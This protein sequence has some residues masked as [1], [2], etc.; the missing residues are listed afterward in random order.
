MTSLFVNR[1]RVQKELFFSKLFTYIWLS[2]LILSFIISYWYFS[3]FPI[4]GTNVLGA[5]T[6]V[7]ISLNVFFVFMMYFVD[8]KLLKTNGL[9][10][11]CG[12]FE[13]IRDNPPYTTISIC[14][15]FF[16]VIALGT[17]GLAQ[18]SQLGGYDISAF[19]NV[20][21]VLLFSISF[22]CLLTIIIQLNIFDCY[23]V[24]KNLSSTNKKRG[25]KTAWMLYIF[26]L[27]CVGF[28]TILLA[29]LLNP[30]LGF[31]TNLLGAAFLAYYYFMRVP[32]SC[33]VVKSEDWLRKFQ[34]LLRLNKWV[35]TNLDYPGP[36]N[37]IVVLLYK[38]SVVGGLR[39]NISHSEQ[40]M[41]PMETHN[42]RIRNNL[43]SL[44]FDGKIVAQISKFLVDKNLHER[45]AAKS[46]IRQA[47]EIL[48]KND[49]S[50][51]FALANKSAKRY[52]LQF[53]MSEI[54]EASYPFPGNR[55]REGMSLLFIDLSDSR[56]RALLE[57]KL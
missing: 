31:I 50:Y 32:F 20:L 7:S 24:I 26:M 2:T 47:Y 38:T 51:A 40:D 28:S 1:S 21:T 41:L 12:D 8:I 42:W 29:L 27:Y 19:H 3:H 23:R 9:L 16:I 43:P 5:S 34:Q 53:G 30:A 48:N 11:Y 36:L 22:I 17:I 6:L 57:A 13:N 54:S 4:S 33:E 15:S 46:L 10:S 44:S 18:Y 49:V 35:D 14:S 25:K 39:I 37:V 45:G 55:F 52:Y 56:S